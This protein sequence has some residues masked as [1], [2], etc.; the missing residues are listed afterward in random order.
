MDVSAHSPSCSCKFLE[1]LPCSIQS[2]RDFPGN[3][4]ASRE[5]NSQKW[6]KQTRCCL[7]QC[8]PARFGNRQNKH[9]IIKG[10]DGT[11]GLLCWVFLNSYAEKTAQRRWDQSGL[12][13]GRWMAINGEGIESI[14]GEGCEIHVPHTRM[15]KWTHSLACRYGTSALSPFMHANAFHCV[16]ERPIISRFRLGTHSYLLVRF[17]LK[18]ANDKGK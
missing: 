9:Y 3:Q 11:W 5:R 14:I 7:G 15:C 18:K 10:L 1:R 4:A 17:V 12:W 16:W 6:R 8:S 13:S 2:L